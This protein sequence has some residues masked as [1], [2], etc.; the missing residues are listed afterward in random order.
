VR[1]LIVASFVSLI[2]GVWQ[3]GWKHGWIDGVTIIVACVIIVTVNTYF[4]AKKE[5][6][7]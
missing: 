2:A 3:D 7:F 5:L 4:E 1:I 6:Q